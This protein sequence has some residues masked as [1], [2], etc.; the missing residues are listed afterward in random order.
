MK[1]LLIHDGFFPHGSAFAS[2]LTN[3]ARLFV[4][5]GYEVHI[6]AAYTKELGLNRNEIQTLEDF[7]FQISDIY[8]RGSIDSFVGPKFFWNDVREYI[9][10]NN[11]DVVFSS[12]GQTY[13][14]KLLRLCRSK[15]ILCLVEQC[16]WLDISAFK[17]GKIDPRYIKMNALFNKG[18]Q[19]R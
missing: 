1:A 16:E 2:R 17:F 19:A 7:S 13:F 10:S 3:M 12:S 4:S 6:I 9:D 11:I 8:N 15:R 14:E 5:I 18:Y